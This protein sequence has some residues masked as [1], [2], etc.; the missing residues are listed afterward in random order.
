[1]KNDK[2][3]MALAAREHI[4]EGKPLTRLE[5]MIFFGIANLPD[6]IAELRKQGWVIKSKQ[7][8]YAM[9]LRRVNEFAVL[10]P[11]PNLPIR[12]LVLTEY[13]LSR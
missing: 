10:K 8:P 9:A 13:W 11:P 3:G 6:L 7:I 2:Y 1:M 4:A 5:A 12:E